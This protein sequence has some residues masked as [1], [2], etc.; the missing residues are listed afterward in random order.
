MAG[1]FDRAEAFLA[2]V[3]IRGGGWVGKAA[4]RVGAVQE[5]Q[6]LGLGL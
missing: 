5:V 2:A 6:W 3:L 1:V 4:Y